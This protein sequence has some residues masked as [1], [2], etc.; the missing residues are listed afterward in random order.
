MVYFV[1]A[2][3]GSPDL[4]TVRGMK[5]LQSADFVIYAGSLVNPELLEFTKK[6]AKI[7]NSAKMT[8]EEVLEV[9]FE[10]DKKNQ[11]V[12]RLHTGDAS[13]YGAIREQ[14]DALD[15]KKIKYE[16]VPGV[17]ACFAAAAS[18]NLE[19]TLPK[20]SQSLIITRIEGKTD[21]PKREKIKSLAAHKTSMAIYLSSGMLKKLCHELIK[22]GYKK[23]TPA[24]L[25]YKASWRDEKKFICTLENLPEVAKKNDISKTAVVLVGDFILHNEYSKSR[26]YSADFETEFRKIKK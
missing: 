6:D 5:L 8:L 4:I 26:L 9:I 3:P 23:N 7:F 14:M 24:A 25:V 17:S 12:V 13:I 22:G 15:E 21:V 18:L 19:F 20:V 2:G 10:A 11:N 16:S 1:G